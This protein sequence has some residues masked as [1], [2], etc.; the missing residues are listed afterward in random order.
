MS[1]SRIGINNLFYGKK[2][3]ENSLALLRN[4]E[5][6]RIKPHVADVKV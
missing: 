5:L 1:K 6:K 3:S 4:A 2:D